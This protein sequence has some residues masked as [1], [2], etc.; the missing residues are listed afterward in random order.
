[1]VTFQKNKKTYKV[2]PHLDLANK[3]VCLDAMLQSDNYFGAVAT[4]N[5]YIITNNIDGFDD[6]KT[7]GDIDKF[8]SDGFLEKM[9]EVNGGS[10]KRDYDDLVHAYECERNAKEIENIRTGFLEIMTRIESQM[11]NID[12]KEMIGRIEKTTKEFKDISK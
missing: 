5:L 8:V 10:L 4:L 3:M 11:E 9:F 12:F 7:V 6:I 1:M 2:N